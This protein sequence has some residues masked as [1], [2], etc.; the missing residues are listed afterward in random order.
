[1]KSQEIGSALLV[2]ED[3]SCQ[4]VVADQ[5]GLR[6]ALLNLVNNALDALA[7]RPQQEP[8]GRVVLSCERNPSGQVV[9]SVDDNG[10]GIPEEVG[11]YLFSGLFSTKGAK[12][13]GMGLLLVQKIV[14]D[15]GG[16]VSYSCP[17]EGGTRFTLVVPEP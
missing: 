13:T 10:P 4:T 11:R 2:R 5:K 14:E 9:I 3:R 12:G 16:Y 1:V 17:L 6:K 8:S 7:S 15:H